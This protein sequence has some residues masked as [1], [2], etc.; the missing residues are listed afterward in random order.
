MK[1][2]ILSLAAAVCAFSAANAQV[3]VSGGVDIVSASIWRGTTCGGPSIQPGATVS[4]AGFSAT[5]W[6]SQEI[7]AS[8]QAAAELDFTFAYSI[9]GFTVAYTNY[10]WTPGTP[11]FEKDTHMSEITL[12][13]EFGESFPLAISIN[14][15]VAGEQDTKINYATKDLKEGQVKDQAFSTYIDF[16]YPF[17]IGSVD[18]TANLGITPWAGMYSGS[19]INPCYSY[20]DEV[21]GED[22]DGYYSKGFQVASV[23]LSFSKTIFETEKF[24]LPLF[25]STSF[26]PAQREAYLVAGMSFGF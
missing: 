26:S 24:A 13:Y 16:S 25:V 5:A 19:Y 20:Y 7:C 10:W 4:Y 17:A 8:G 15:I 2:F 14:T 21:E 11:Y 9:A 3:E 6:A 23:G 22:V 1:K 18:C 12:G